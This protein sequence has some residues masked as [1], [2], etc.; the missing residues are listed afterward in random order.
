MIVQK[1]ATCWAA[2]GAMMISWRKQQMLSTEAA[3]AG[4]GNPYG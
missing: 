2:A 3:I 4:T 1:G